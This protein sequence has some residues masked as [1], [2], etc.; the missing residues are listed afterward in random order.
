MWDTLLPT[1]IDITHGYGRMMLQSLFFINGAGIAGLITLASLTTQRRPELIAESIRRLA[2]SIAFTAMSAA[3]GFISAYAHVYKEK[4]FG[5]IDADLA[6]QIAAYLTPIAGAA[7][8][9][10]VGI[11]IFW[12][13]MG[14]RL[15]ADAITPPPGE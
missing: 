2:V 13:Y 1:E 15:L 10:C 6:A 4:R 3:A 8:L 12:S 9:V 11:A 5:Q 14:A 7:M